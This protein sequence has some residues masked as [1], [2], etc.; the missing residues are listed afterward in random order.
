MSGEVDHACDLTSELLAQC[1][2][3]DSATI[4]SD[5]G[6]LRKTLARWLRHPKVQAVYPALTTALHG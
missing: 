2:A 4:R 3:A 5:L 6:D 1:V